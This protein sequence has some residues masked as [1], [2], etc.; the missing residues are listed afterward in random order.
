MSWI[1]GT[2]IRIAVAGVLAL[3]SAGQ[4]ATA[5]DAPVALEEITVTAEKRVST[6]QETPISIAAFSGA[7]LADVGVNDSYGLANL[8]P[9]LTIQK[10]FIGKVVIRGVGVESTT[11]GSDPGVAIHRDGAYVARSSVAVFDFFDVNRIEVLRGPQGTLYGRN[12]TGGVINIHSNHPEKE[13]GG[14]A[15]LEFGNYSKL[16]FEGAVTGPL[17][18]AVQ[19]RLSVLYAQRDGYTENLFP[20]AESRDVDQLDNQ[21]LVAV[22]GQVNFDLSDDVSLLLL[23]ELSRD[24]SNTPAY[25]YF[26]TT[27]AWWFDAFGDDQDLPNLRQVSQGFE[28]EIP[29]SDRSMPSAGQADQDAYLAKLTWNLGNMT[30]TSLSAYRSIDYAWLNDGDGFDTFFVQYGQHDESDQFT[31]EFQLAS[32]GDSKLQWIL[33]AYYLKEDAKTFMAI[34]F[35]IGTPND[36]IMWDGRSDTEGYAVFGQATYAFTDRL[37]LTAG[38]RYNKEEKQGDLVYDVFGGLVEPPGALGEPAGTTWADILDE[39][40]DATTPKL[41][42]DYDFTDDV[43]AYASA[44]RGFKSG[45]FN[46]LAAQY[47]YDPETLWAYELGLKTRWADGRVI[48][49]FGAFVYDY[50]DMQVGQIANLTATIVNAGAATIQG[51]EAEVRA[52]VGNGFEVNAGLAWLD[53]TY[54]EFETEDPG[55]PGDAGCGTLVTAPRTI[56]LKGCDLPRSPEFQGALGVTW[57]RALAS[58]GEFSVRGDYFY[59]SE[60]FFTQFNRDLVSQDSYSLLNARVTYAAPESRWSITAYGNNLADEDYFVTVFESGVSVPGTVV[61]GAIMGAPRTY[62]VTLDYDF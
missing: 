7:E 10:E 11:I 51:L 1:S 39:G 60:Q 19:G 16:R 52:L 46:L 3:A 55:W 53:A 36:Y 37:R 20:T 49:N 62:G 38:L 42:L 35:I 6:V 41:A 13:L 9:S 15:R 18:E 56:S 50:E 26:D 32:S 23:A 28:T 58:G 34:P 57:S 61:P 25:K 40:W 4:P 44:T 33:G 31:Q 24:D 30:F 47:P 5:A 8:T 29:G 12:A 14:Y 54:D 43:M 21:D 27:N 17:G 59:R 48:A 2:R 45:G 22:R